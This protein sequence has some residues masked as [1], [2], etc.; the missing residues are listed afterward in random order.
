M[1]R[2]LCSFL[3][4]IFLSNTS[5]SQIKLP[6]LVRD[7]MVLQRDIKVNIWGWA[8]PGENVTASFNGKKYQT[9]TDQEGK[10][11]F[12]LAPTKAGGPYSMEITGKNKIVLKEILVGDVWF[13]SG[14]SNMVHQMNIHDVTYAKD[15][16][17]A[18]NSQIRQFWIPTLTHLQGAQNDLPSGYWKSAVGEDVRPFSAVAYFFAKKFTSNTKYLLAS[19]MPA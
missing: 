1:K 11:I 4:L 17:E 19:S 8:S 18:N 15:I 16:A 7:S 9:K 12:Q 3:G 6:Q 14:Q 2:I 5:M 10:W 13:C